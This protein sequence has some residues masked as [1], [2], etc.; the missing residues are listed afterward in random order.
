[1]SKKF[2]TEEQ[3]ALLL[4]NQYV[5]WCSP[6]YLT[7]TDACKQEAIRLHEMGWISSK[8]IFRRLS[9]PGFIVDSSFPR[10]SMKKWRKIIKLKWVSWLTS[11][12]KGRKKKEKAKE[13]ENRTPEE[14][15]L[16]LEAKIAYLEHEND[17]LRL[18]RAQ[19]NK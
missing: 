15:I 17:F 13:I 4:Q 9:F 8:D 2:Y 19:R 11:K 14:Q 3:I 10:E 12:K 6:K 16:Y 1:M 5:A 7:I 18:L